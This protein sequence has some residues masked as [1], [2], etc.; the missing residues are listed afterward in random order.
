MSDISVV[1]QTQVLDVT[2][3]E[4]HIDVNPVTHQAVVVNTPTPS[5]SITNAGPPGPRGASA[6]G[7]TFNQPTESDSWV[8]NHN[9]GF[10]P[11]VQ[12]F[13]AGGLEVI[14]EIHHISINQVVISFNTPMSGSA[15]LS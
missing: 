6:I 14:G 2:P 10:A 11:S 7:F 9:L 8:I 5:V 12:V 13:N 3:S 1:A 15:R 4:Q